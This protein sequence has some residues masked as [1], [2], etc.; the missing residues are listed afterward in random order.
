MCEQPDLLVPA[1]TTANLAG[2]HADHDS[3]IRIARSIAVH[4]PLPDLDLP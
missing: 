1:L 3:D 2:P 4:F